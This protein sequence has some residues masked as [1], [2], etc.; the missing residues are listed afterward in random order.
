MIG[1]WL[2]TNPMGGFAK[3]AIGAML[4]WII[5]NLSTL[6]IPEIAQVG[7]IAGLPIL[8]NWLNPGD[9]RYGKLS[10]ETRSE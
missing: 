7:L 9:A 4:V 1:A 6:Q 10:D 8:I 5:D 2:A 3:V